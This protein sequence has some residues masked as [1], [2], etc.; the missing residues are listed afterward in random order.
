M[1][2]AN[3]GPCDGLRRA[4]GVVNRWVLDRDGSELA[5]FDDHPS[6]VAGLAFSKDG[7]QIACAHYEGISVHHIDEPARRTDKLDWHGSHTLVTWSPD[8]KFIVSAMQENEMHCWR[9]PEGKGMRM[10]GYPKKI[11]ALSWTADGKF[12]AASG[13]DTVTSWSFAGKGPP[14]GA[15]RVR[16]RLQ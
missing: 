16:L 6:T 11:R 14:Q 9:M 1:G 8:G 7:S 12:L 13:A 5:R 2:R 4:Y 10:S 15:D 3:R